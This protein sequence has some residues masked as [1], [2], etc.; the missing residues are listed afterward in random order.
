MEA[1]FSKL[2][3]SVNKNTDKL[4]SIEKAVQKLGVQATNVEK[5]DK[6]KDKQ[7][8]KELKLLQGIKETLVNSEKEASKIRKE[9]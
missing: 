2:A 5:K 9:T 7:N 1:I 6:E 3:D 8:D 4:S